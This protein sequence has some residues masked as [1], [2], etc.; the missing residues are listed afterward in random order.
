MTDLFSYLNSDRDELAYEAVFAL[1]SIDCH[2]GTIIRGLTRIIRDERGHFEPTSD[3]Y[4][5][6]EAGRSFWATQA[7]QIMRPASSG[8]IMD[9][10]RTTES[11]SN[12]AR[13]ASISVLSQI[14]DASE[15]Y[16]YLMDALADDD[17]VVRFTAVELTPG[18]Q[19]K[20]GAEERR[21][22]LDNVIK[23]LSDEFL[24]IRTAAISAVAAFGEPEI[25]IPVLENVAEHDDNQQV[26]W[27]ARQ[28][29]ERLAR[30]TE[31]RNIK[32]K[33]SN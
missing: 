9:L 26:R 33:G 30:M 5:S 12:I 4:F 17:R 11:N 1:C 18:L 22:L 32:E 2:R 3:L 16:P 14:L 29:A 8:C 24:M 21:A 27:H 31:Q 28:A 13:C 20:F 19:G 6:G 10:I 23:L 7:L 15:Y 25:A